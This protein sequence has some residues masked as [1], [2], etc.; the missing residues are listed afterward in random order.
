MSKDKY[1]LTILLFIF[2]IISIIYLLD[3]KGYDKGYQ[4]G[5]DYGYQ[6]GE[7]RGLLKAAEEAKKTDKW[8]EHLYVT[9][10]YC[11]LNNLSIIVVPE[12]AAGII[13][14]STKNVLVMNNIIKL[15]Q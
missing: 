14:K 10:D 5:Y 12:P 7:H 11:N 4:R 6:K 8:T 2:G 9:G 1:T 15:V 3:F 13:I